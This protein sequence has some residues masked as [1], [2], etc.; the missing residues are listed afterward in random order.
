M[1]RPRSASRPYDNNIKTHVPASSLPPSSLSKRVTRSQSREQDDTGR[2]PS[3]E[4]HKRNPGAKGLDVVVEESPIKSPRKSGSRFVNNPALAESHEDAGNISGTT[5]ML[6]EPD[7]T[8]DTEMMLDTIPEL[9]R[10]ANG[11]LELLLPNSKDMVSIVNSAKKLADPRNTQNR[12]FQHK[13]SRLASETKGFTH[14]TYIDVAHVDHLIS[15]FLHDTHGG[16]SS[17]WSPD[18]ILYKANC[19]QFA[20]E[21]LVASGD[22]PA[23]RAI[24]NVKNIYPSGFMGD[25]VSSDGQRSVGNSTLAQQTFQLALEIRTQAVIMEIEDRQHGL[26]FDSVSVL[27]DGFF[28][29]D[30]SGIV[31][32][33]DAPLR[34]FGVV[35]LGGAGGRLPTHFKDAAWDRYEELRLLLPSDESDSL[36]V[37]DLKGAFRWQKF[38]LKAAQW[39]RKRIEEVDIDLGSQ[40][41]AEDVNQVFFNTTRDSFDGTDDASSILTSRH[42]KERTPASPAATR[43]EPNPAVVTAGRRKSGK[44]PFLNL[45]ALH[46]LAQ[47]QKEPRAAAAGAQPRRKSDIVQPVSQPTDKESENRRRTLPAPSQMREEA[48]SQA[49][50]PEIPESPEYQHFPSDEELFVQEDSSLNIEKSHSP[51]VR[52]RRPRDLFAANPP[53]Q[54]D[55]PFPASQIQSLWRPPNPNKPTMLPP[56]RPKAAP[57][58]FIDRQHTAHRVS[59]ISQDAG[60][61][62]RPAP[63][64]RPVA[65]VVQSRKRPRDESADSSSFSDW[66]RAVGIANRRAQK[67]DQSRHKR[68]RAEEA[69]DHNGEAASQQARSDVATRASSSEAEP[70]RAPRRTFAVRRSGSKKPRCRWTDLEDERLVRLIAKHGTGWRDIEQ[71]NEAQPVREGE[72]RFVGRDQVAIKDRARNLKYYFYRHGLPLPCGFENVTFKSSDVKKLRAMGIEV[73]ERCPP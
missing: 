35:G 4:I 45:A 15:S 39:I 61:V 31:D 17:D 25:L 14:G 60:S 3:V 65:E 41:S 70:P 8:L 7:T 67:P 24:T 72:M 34:G 49:E 37:A 62:G 11:V 66:D 69:D 68:V 16:S 53:S 33:S 28:V 22:N 9:E 63:R 20:R 58:S 19:A 27:N 42:S 21:I 12:R 36:N 30:P 57:G 48:A 55:R 64:G 47:R 50:M 2:R 5:L 29:D 46:T 56:L 18:P 43:T 23:R 10:A 38:V 26:S 59:P 44:S 52:K 6:S 32:S 71:D 54:E 51:P 73:P 40:P 13:I 1:A